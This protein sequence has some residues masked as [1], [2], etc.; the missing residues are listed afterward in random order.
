MSTP[1]FVFGTEDQSPFQITTRREIIKLLQGIVDHREQVTVAFH[2]GSEM[3]LSRLLEIDEK[4]DLIYIDC[5]QNPGLNDKIA[6]S[7]GVAFETALER[8]RILFSAKKVRECV[9]GG[10]AALCCAIPASLIRLQRRE[11]FRVNIPFDRQVECQ[12]TLPGGTYNLPLVDISCGGI[13][14]LDEQ[15]LLNTSDDL[16]YSGCRIELGDG[17]RVELTLKI[18]STL[19]VALPSGKSIRR[20]G[21][22]FYDIQAGGMNIVQRYIMQLERERN[23]RLH[24]LK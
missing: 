2:G 21:C 14:I 12:I 17:E 1:S 16:L 10:E 20:L 8:I 5:S 6:A 9:H 7:D 24:A 23:A 18:C 3:L 4:K 11:F 13:A 19:D 22:Q 15:H